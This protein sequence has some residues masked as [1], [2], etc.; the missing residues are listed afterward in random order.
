MPAAPVPDPDLAAPPEALPPASPPDQPP[1]APA[2]AP[3]PPPDLPEAEV[4]PRVRL[5]SVWL[6]PLLALL[7]GGWLAWKSYSERGPEIQIAF[8]SATG[9]QAERTKVKF[10]DVEIGQVTGI[11]VSPDLTHVLVKAR[12][13]AGSER[14]LTDGTR[15]WVARPRI[16]ATEVTGLETL[17]SGPYIAI[18]P[19]TAGDSRREFVGLDT[20]PLVTTAEPGK[21]FVLKAGSLGSLNIGS[22]VF[23]RAIQVGQVVSYEL[24]PDDQGV[25]IRVF[26]SSPY[27]RLVLTNTRFWNASG[28]DVRLTTDGIKVETDS[29]LS[30][31]IGGVA[32]EN[33]RTLEAEGTPAPD[34][35]AFPLYASQEKAS[36]TLYTRR[37]SYLLYFEGSVHGLEIG[38]PVMVGGIK[39]GQVLDIRLDFDPDHRNIQ[40]PV[41]IEL[42]PQRIEDAPEVAPG[43]EGNIM[44]ELV[45]KGLR[46]QLKPASL[47]SGK[48]YVDLDLHPKAPPAALAR[49]GDLAVIPTVPAPLDDIAN[50]VSSLLG[51]LETLPIEAIGNDLRDAVHGAKGVLNSEALANALMEL[52]ASLR[53]LRSAAQVVDEQ[54]LPKLA[55]AVDQVRT[56]FKSAQEVIAP[57]TALYQDIKRA[58]TELSAAARATRDLADFLERHPEALIKG[59]GAR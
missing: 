9:L 14:Y 37:V 13:L 34:N 23:Y 22:P 46:G 48:L 16:S 42:E 47:L 45:A 59:K 18:D 58:V 25:S 8:K 3:E 20:P 40:I 4:A 15:F 19:V 57:D 10:M 27:E 32:F 24:D 51:K 41:L 35:Q 43:E 30:I 28:I 54:T 56:T 29:L 5:S 50:K 33:V 53:A 55:A 52:E 6:I 11:S 2:L 17:L 36:E 12:L 38:A 21:H 39:I 1:P 44:A 49:Q 26:V 31:L 7:I